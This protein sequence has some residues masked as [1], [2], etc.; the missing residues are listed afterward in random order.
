MFHASRNFTING[1]YFGSAGRDLI[2]TTSVES[3][4]QILQRHTS[5][6]AL[7]NAGARYPPPHVY[8]G[9][10]AAF[11]CELEAWARSKTQRPL[12][13]LCGSPGVGKTTIAQTFAET[14]AVNRTLAAS[15]FFGRSD[16]SRNCAAPLFSTLALQMTVTIPELR[17]IIDEIIDN[18]PFAP[19]SL[20]MDQCNELIIEPWLKLKSRSSSS[21]TPHIL[22]I[23]GLDECSN[24]HNE[25]KSILSLLA[26]IV[27]HCPPIRILLCS[28]PEPRIKECLGTSPM[29]QQM[30]LDS[31][32]SYR[33]SEDI[34]KFLMN[35]FEEIW[36]NHSFS[37][38]N[39]PRP[40]PTSAQVKCLVQK[41]SGQFIY[42]ALVITYVDKDGGHPPDRLNLIMGL[43]VIHHDDGKAQPFVELDALY[44]HILSS[45]DMQ[46]LRRE[47]F[48]AAIAYHETW[49][50]DLPLIDIL[51]IDPGRLHAAFFG[52][53][54][55][56]KAP[57]PI[58]SNFQ[59]CHL[60][61]ME[62]LLDSSR[63]L[64]FHVDKSLG[65][66]ILARRFIQIYKDEE[67]TSSV[68]SPNP[69]KWIFH[70]VRASITDEL[71][72]ELD[73]VE[74]YR[75]VTTKARQFRILNCLPWVEKLS[76]TLLSIFIVWLQFQDKCGQRLRNLHNICTV[77]FTLEIM[78]KV[79]ED[80][81][82]MEPRSVAIRYPYSLSSLPVKT[83][84]DV[85]HYLV[86]ELQKYLGLEVKKATQKE[87][88]QFK[89]V[90]VSS[91]P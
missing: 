34:T 66:S 37:M 14:C 68:G 45:G 20:T 16:P 80:V 47:V 86:A 90:K 25:W 70:C 58:Q 11:L 72:S 9:T 28:R 75:A 39:V 42:P 78:D 23:D 46:T 82:R 56:F 5:N 71:I 74:I 41:S 26:S 79:N 61:L 87:C 19:T 77:G 10:R 55:L 85:E 12:L 51:G 67:K 8:P 7:H 91:L 3:G 53:H 35:R 36:T 89:F 17:P 13:W 65:H 48:A 40:W 84:L 50:Q 18:N 6:S 59:F 21:T 83:I 32:S 49:P 60:S 62:Y 57:S 1:G 27:H 63:S 38:Q 22:I 4:L 30:S 15:F 73:S 29:C 31:E 64:D 76:Q 2:F 69:S 81:E 54:S 43:P 24:E 44:R 52:L 33:A 88:D